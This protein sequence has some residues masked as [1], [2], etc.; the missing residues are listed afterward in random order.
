MTNINNSNKKNDLIK[1]KILAKKIDNKIKTYIS[2]QNDYDKLIEKQIIENK[3]SSGGW[4]DV[5]QNYAAGPYG[6]TDPRKST[7]NW[8]YLGQFNNID[9]CKIKAV[10][11][12]SDVYSNIVYDTTDNE[13]WGKTCYAGI[14]GGITNPQYQSG[15]ITS[16]APNG[17]S[18]FGGSDGEK[19]L[20]QIKQIQN[21]I[22]HFILQAKND[23]VTLEKYYKLSLLDKKKSDIQID[24]LLD[25][26]TQ[27][28]ITINKLLLEP[29][30]TGE[31]ENSNIMKKSNYSIYYLWTLIVLISIVLAFHLILSPN[32]NISPITYIFVTIWILILFKY[33]Y[34]IALT[35]GNTF[36]DY[37]STIMVD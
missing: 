13:P 31:N 24:N 23:D 6:P 35:Y 4:K 7:I 1:S 17:S 2:L 16:L 8:K 15:I 14:K 36:W 5:N 11:D 30:T 34:K 27:D 32:E 9:E 22:N 29:N 26:L 25:N 10:Q 28:R 18:R 3:E 33:Y 19:I 12:K 37:I 20:K 21:E